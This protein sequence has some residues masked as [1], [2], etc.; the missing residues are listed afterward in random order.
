M[1]LHLSK[2]LTNQEISE[3]FEFIAGVLTVQNADHFRIRAYEVAG[4]AISQWGS[5]LTE[6]I[7]AQESI[8]DIPGIGESISQ[9]LHELVKTGHIKAFEQYVKDIPA[10]MRPLMKVRGIGPKTAFLFAKT[11]QLTKEATALNDVQELCQQHRIKTLENFGEK[12][13]NLILQAINDYQ[14]THNR[15]PYPIAFKLAQQVIGQLNQDKS[16]VKIAA[17]G[18]LRRQTPTVGDI[19]IGLATTN[20]ASVKNT[21]KKMKTVKKIVAIG[22]QMMRLL[23]DND[24][25][26]DIKLVPPA[27]WGS[28][29]QHFTG[30]KAHNIK[31]REFALSQ[32]YSLSEHGIKRLSDHKIFTFTDE[33]KF[34]QFLGLKW[35]K[36]EDRLGEAELETAKM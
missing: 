4:Y 19:D 27:E 28:F 34:Y 20:S 30:S 26:V 12:S 36:P 23:L 17:L 14:T 32:G 29:I 25:Q 31:L 3:L 1:Q 2:N 10:G 8:D 6:M 35:I 5:E 21:V 15:L 9:K 13:E 16:I 22:D 24:I 11:F 18:S 7:R 33:K